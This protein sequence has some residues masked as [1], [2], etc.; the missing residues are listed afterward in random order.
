MQ[1]NINQLALPTHILEALSGKIAP[2]NAISRALKNNSSEVV[3][4]ALIVNL[5]DKIEYAHY[6]IECNAL[7][8][9]TS[10]DILE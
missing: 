5:K 8:D 6:E 1:V 2:V 3:E 10:F 9:F 4:N 7:S